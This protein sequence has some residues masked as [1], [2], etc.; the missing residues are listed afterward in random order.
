MQ[1][2]LMIMDGTNHADDYILSVIF[3]SA[4]SFCYRQTSVGDAR[5]A[6]EQAST[7]LRRVPLIHIAFAQFELLQ[8]KY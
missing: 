1:T 7:K 2:T 8:G 3:A 6:F 5:E 4:I